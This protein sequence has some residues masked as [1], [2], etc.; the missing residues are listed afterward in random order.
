MNDPKLDTFVC[1]HSR[2]VGYLLELVLRSYEVNFLPKGRL[3]LIT[4]DA[5]HLQAFIDRT[6]IVPNAIVTADN[7][8]LSVRELALPGWYKQQII[9]L[10]AYKFCET[11][12][13]CNLGADTILLK[14]IAASDLIRGDFPI[15]YYTRHRFPD[16]HVRFERERIG[17]V[18]SILRVEP[19]NA[20]RYVDFINDLFTFNREVVTF[21]YEYLESMY[22]SDPYATLL[23]GMDDKNTPRNRFGE[24]TLYS[25]FLLD[26][27]RKDITLLN[28]R[29]T[30]LHQVHSKLGL[31]LYPFNTKVAHFVGKDFDVDYIKQQISRHAPELSTVL[32]SS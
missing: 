8:W 27:L 22:G 2:D 21:L 30:F 16:A 13:F 1:V 17:Y 9:K 25:V 19:T 4:N 24:W 29:P 10:R 23:A 11:E 3:T 7:D 14:P 26:Y 15:L 12:N 18:A 31:R 20:L 28:T 32:Q 6:G 5:P